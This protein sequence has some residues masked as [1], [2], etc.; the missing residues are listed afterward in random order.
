M[1]KQKLNQYLLSDRTKL[2][3][4]LDGAAVADLP[5][6]LYEMRPPNYCLLSGEL[7]PDIQYTAPYVVNL[8]PNN[9]FTDWVLAESFGKNWGIFVHCRFSITEMRRHFRSLVTVYDEQANP[10]LFRFYDP[11]VLRRFLPT[12]NPAELKNFFGKVQTYFAETEDNQNLLSFQ[13]EN[14]ILKDAKLDLAS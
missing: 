13:L 9:N 14:D 3:C 4:V 12:C 10:M 1:D 6:R 8:L 2:Y 5:M 11:R 7:A